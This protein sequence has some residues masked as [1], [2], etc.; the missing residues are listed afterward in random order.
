MR[1]VGGANLWGHAPASELAPR[2][3]ASST[4]RGARRAKDKAVALQ[5]AEVSTEGARGAPGAIG[6]RIEVGGG[7]GGAQKLDVGE[8][9]RGVRVEARKQRGD[10]LGVTQ[11]AGEEHARLML[12]CG[13]T[14]D[15]A[16]HRDGFSAGQARQL[17]GQGCASVRTS[18]GC[19]CKQRRLCETW[20]GRGQTDGIAWG[21]G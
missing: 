20:A 10:L 16:S 1:R 11:G 17:I 3:L 12:V 9:D 8:Q 13:D 6:E 18:G 14:E 2:V 19:G 5:H 4:C 21:I 7:D 15:A